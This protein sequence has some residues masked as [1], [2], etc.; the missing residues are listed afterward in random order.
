MEVARRKL[1]NISMSAVQSDGKDN[2]CSQKY[3]HINTTDG[4]EIT[5]IKFLIGCIT[6]SDRSEIRVAYELE[7][8]RV[9][10]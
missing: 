10:S 7:C 6:T 2:K 1:R 9:T 5:R 8:W 4:G 3:I